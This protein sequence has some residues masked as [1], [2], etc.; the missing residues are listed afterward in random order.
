MT[1][2]PESD[3]H[4]DVLGQE[5]AAAHAAVLGVVAGD[6]LR[7]GLGEVERRRGSSRPSPAMRKIR[8]PTICGPMYQSR[9]LLRGRCPPARAT[10]PSSPRRAPTARARPRTRR[11]ARTCASRRAGRTSIPLAQPPTMNAV[12][13]DRA[14]REDQEQRRS[15]RRRPSRRRVAADLPPGPHGMTANAARAVKRR[16]R[17]ARCDVEALDWP[18]AGQKLLLADQLH[19]VG[20]RLEQSERAGAVR[21]VAGLDA[22]DELALEPASVRE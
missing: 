19:Q 20:D 7:L 2:S 11:A 15:A 9:L 3:D 14:E 21:P 10:G 13:P 12:D 4:V 17:P 5:E 22:A 1:A 8:K 16:D 6:E 18:A